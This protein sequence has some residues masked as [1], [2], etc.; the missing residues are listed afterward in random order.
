M[1]DNISRLISADGEDNRFQLGP[2]LTQI[3]SKIVDAAFKTY[4]T[5][6]KSGP[7]QLHRAIAIGLATPH[8]VCQDPSTGELVL[9]IGVPNLPTAVLD[10]L[11]T[12]G[13]F[14]NALLAIG[15]SCGVRPPGQLLQIAQFCLERPRDLLP[16]GVSLQQ[17]VTGQVITHLFPTLMLYQLQHCFVRFTRIVLSV[18]SSQR[19]VRHRRITNYQQPSP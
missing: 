6:D 18:P 5:L 8:T 12:V 15:A 16:D 13:D 4:P 1:A 10:P 2:T 19:A 14:I 7:A 17:H 3:C 11:G 9:L